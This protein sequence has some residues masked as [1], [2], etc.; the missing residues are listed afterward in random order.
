[1]HRLLT[2]EWGAAGRPVQ[3]VGEKG[4]LTYDFALNLNPSEKFPSEKN[5]YGTGKNCSI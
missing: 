5:C 2:E 3:T 4:S 1:M